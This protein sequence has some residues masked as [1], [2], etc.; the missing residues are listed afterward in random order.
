MKSASATKFHRKSEVAEGPAVQR[1]F[2]VKGFGQAYP[3]TCPSSM[4]GMSRFNNCFRQL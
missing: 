2:L 3:T 4:A 1:T